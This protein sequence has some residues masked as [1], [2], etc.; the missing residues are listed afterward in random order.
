MEKT[1]LEKE[2]LIVAEELFVDKGFAATST[3][4]IA[5]AVGCNQALVHYYYRTKENL[6]QQIFIEKIDFI[7]SYLK[8]FSFEGD[9]LKLVEMAVNGCFT[10]LSTNRKMPFFI[11]SE[12]IMNPARREFIRNYV[13]ENQARRDAYY[14]IDKI[15]KEEAV[16]GH[17]R[18]VETL[19]LLLNFMSLV[20]ST[21][22]ALPLY[23]DWLQKSDEEVNLFI[24]HRRQDVL[25]MILGSLK[26]TENQGV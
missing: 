18:P 1:A 26:P 20:T 21:F 22:T 19:D 24:D 7:L 14:K 8:D 10:M 13:I 11:L 23:Q 2:I 12:L 6:F 17:I 25:N 16:K 5:R 3:T 4:D 15:L 9:V